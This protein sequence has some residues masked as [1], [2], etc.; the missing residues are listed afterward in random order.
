MENEKIELKDRLLAGVAYFSSLLA[1]II[2]IFYWNRKSRRS[3]VS[4][5][6]LQSLTL[7]VT[8]YLLGFVVG[9][10]IFTQGLATPE[11]FKNGFPEWLNWTW[12]LLLA[13]LFALAASGSRF[14]IPLICNAVD[15][16]FSY[17]ERVYAKADEAKKKKV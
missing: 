12:W 10:V 11:S 3:F 15:W 13:A 16:Y 8:L 9:I 6:C 5:H 1:I 4:Y 7:N 2:G 14:R 17:I